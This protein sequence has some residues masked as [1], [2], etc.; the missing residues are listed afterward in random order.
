MAARVL[1]RMAALCG[2]LGDDGMIHAAYRG[3]CRAC[4]I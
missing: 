1:Y 2:K 3:G 4:T